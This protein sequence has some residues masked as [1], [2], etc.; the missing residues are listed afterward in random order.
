MIKERKM[1]TIP[2]IRLIR[3]DDEYKDILTVRNLVFVKEQNVPKDIEFDGLDKES[4]HVIAKL[5]KKTIGCARV[6][7]IDGKLKLERIAVLKEYRSKGF[8]KRLM[9]Y[10]ILYCE[11]RNAEEIVIHAQ[12]YLKRFYERLGFKP[13]GEAFLEAGIKHVEMYIKT[14]KT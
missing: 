6:R 12:Y 4:V 1:S 7:S 3:D 8:G 10:L 14:P 13:R 9:Q 5:D 2:E 11:E